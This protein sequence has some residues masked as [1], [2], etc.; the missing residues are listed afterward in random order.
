[1]L[2][3]RCLFA[4]FDKCAVE[5]AQQRIADAGL[6][7]PTLIVSSGHGAHAYW[8]L[9]EPLT[10]LAAWTETQKDLIDLLHS[11]KVIF[12]PER[13]MRLP[14]FLNLKGDPV[15]VRIVEVGNGN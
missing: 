12:N 14:G 4:D 11:D 15:P 1:V 2:L 6:P 8:R 13:L 10:D 5:A 7:T 9:T 3:A